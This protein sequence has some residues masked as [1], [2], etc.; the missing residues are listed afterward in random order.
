MS[1]RIISFGFSEDRFKGKAAKRLT[2]YDIAGKE[3]KKE[4]QRQGSETTKFGF[5]TRAKSPPFVRQM[6]KSQLKSDP[7]YPKQQA[8]D[9][10]SIK[11]K[12]RIGTKHKAERVAK[13]DKK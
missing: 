5:R 7:Y 12:Q 9:G 6:F 8:Y 4:A 11:T 3:R 2:A 10:Y 13:A 1:A